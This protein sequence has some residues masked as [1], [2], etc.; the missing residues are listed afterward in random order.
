MLII[1][2]FKLIFSSVVSAVITIAVVYI[3]YQKFG[4]V[5]VAQ[6]AYNH[7]GN[8]LHFDKN[9]DSSSVFDAL[10]G[11][12]NYPYF[13]GIRYNEAG[14]CV[15]E[16]KYTDYT[17]VFREKGCAKLEY[18][19]TG[20]EE[21]LRLILR[22]ATSIHGYLNKFFDPELPYDAIKDFRKLKLAEK[23]QNGIQIAIS[24]ASA[25]LIAVFVIYM[26]K[27]DIIK[28][29]AA[30]RGSYLS[31]YSDKVTIEEAFDSFF[32]KEKWRTYKENGYSYVA[33][34]GVCEFME[35]SVDVRINFKITGDNFRVDSMDINGVEQGDLMVALLLEKIYEEYE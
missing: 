1:V 5:R 13:K 22:E 18:D 19:I 6:N 11:K 24:T 4:A 10:N 27:P 30:V 25:I 16:G 20:K 35:K 12:F 26:V 8:K 34:T 2:L 17:I 29:G 3:V 14:S 32:A 7:A 23:Q 9:I 31:Q 28:P 33:F 15:I 21:K